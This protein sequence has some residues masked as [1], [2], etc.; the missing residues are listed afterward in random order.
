M[1]KAI[2]F[3]FGQTLVDSAEGFR[4]AE[5]QAETKI[6]KDLGLESWP[7]FLEDY[8]QLR[9]K[10]HAQSIFSRMALWQKV[11]S[12]YAREPN[13]ELISAAE[14]DY[15]EMVNSKTRPFPETKV[16]LE[17]LATKYRLALIT[18]TQGQQSEG[19]H[20]ISL[21]PEI[22]SLFE[23][24]IVAG[25]NDVPPKPDSKSFIKCLG[26]LGIDPSNAIFVGDDWRIDI[27]G[28]QA[29][30]IHPVWIKHHSISRNWPLI[31]TPGPIITSLE[32][33]LSL[34]NIGLPSFG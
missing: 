24:I 32:Q 25:E 5:K 22:E 12:C 2:I 6:F 9:K 21:F 34:E 15:W 4:L 16:V 28:A 31:E 11:Y 18:N 23:V 7:D 29:A 20:R 3:D 33:L 17:Q 8:R 19:K 13:D 27:C 30:G 14:G 26:I 1:I 10:L